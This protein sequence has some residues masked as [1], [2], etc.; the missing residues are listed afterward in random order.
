MKDLGLQEVLE[1]QRQLERKKDDLARAV[2]E[3]VE[4]Q[5]RNIPRPAQLQNLRTVAAGTGSLEELKI[6]VQYQMSRSA[7][8]I[9]PSF[10][11]ALLK[12]LPTNMEEARIFLGYLYRYARYKE[13]KE[14]GTR[15][16][17]G[18]RR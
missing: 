5:S 14:V 7:A 8:P 10:G 4:S 11:E 1:R 12:R 15:R 2:Y 16:R 18:R 6:F 13:I 17:G 9:N 3:L